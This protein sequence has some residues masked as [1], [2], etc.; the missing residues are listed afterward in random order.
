MFNNKILIIDDEKLV[1][2]TIS[3]HLI[4]EGY[5]I[6]SAINGKDGL[7]IFEK[8][9]PV[10]I[11]LDL[12]MPVMTGMEWLEHIK[13]KPFDP[14]SV[15]VLTG[16]GSDEDVEKCFGMGVSAFLRKPFNIFELKGLVRH[17]IKL[18]E[19]QYELYKH[20]DHL[21]ELVNIRTLELKATQEKLIQSEKLAAIG[22][23]SAAISHEFNNPICSI[24]GALQ[25]I[26]NN[27][28]DKPSDLIEMVIQE[29]DKITGFIAKLDDFYKPS[30][31]KVH[32]TDINNVIDEM[33]LFCDQNFKTKGIELERDYTAGMPKIKVVPDQI[34]QAILYLLINAEQAITKDGG[35]IMVRTEIFEQEIKIHIQDNGDG[36]A[37]KKTKSIFE[38][39]FST[40]VVQ[41]A[42]LGLSVSYGIV[43]KHGGDIT[44]QSQIGKG[45]TFTIM[46]PVDGY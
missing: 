13:L 35:K 41:G 24:R 21:E 45:S 43:K 10:L 1:I 28:I 27:P 2:N 33:L 32:P 34:K 12:K 7:E 19:T 20:R 38:P 25:L 40:K 11:I 22:R 31:G 30:S 3:K 37:P 5:E 8:D 6:V 16:Y 46:L 23:L 14:F 9:H 36:I 4:T 42:G 15:I 18:K 44:F 39:F 17:C 26:Q 29:C